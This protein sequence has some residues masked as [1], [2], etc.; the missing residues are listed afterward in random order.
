M[1]QEYSSLQFE[2]FSI[3]P[4]SLVSLVIPYT[5]P[6]DLARFTVCLREA[7]DSCA[8]GADDPDYEKIA[9]KQTGH[10]YNFVL[11]PVLRVDTPIGSGH[12]GDV[13][14]KAIE[15][16]EFINCASL[17]RSARSSRFPP[18]SFQSPSPPRSRRSCSTARS[19]A[20][21]PP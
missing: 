17:P 1:S 16:G 9:M 4:L 14:L 19:V 6:I 11:K 13:L 20:S 2:T 7:V 18:I 15:E 12:D 21:P 5:P 3:Q 8:L 10:R